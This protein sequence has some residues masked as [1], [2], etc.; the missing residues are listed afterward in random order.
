MEISFQIDSPEDNKGKCI[1]FWKFKRK[2]ELETIKSLTSKS[3]LLFDDFYEQSAIVDED[4]GKK[5]LYVGHDLI[6]KL[7][8]SDACRNFEDLFKHE[9]YLKWKGIITTKYPELSALFFVAEKKA[10][11]NQKLFQIENVLNKQKYGARFYNI[12]HNKEYIRSLK[13]RATELH[14][15]LDSKERGHEIVVG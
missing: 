13:Q 9:K 12:H 14:K 10:I 3:G 8:D 4:F 15:Q 1:C 11:I 7:P 5:P 2:Y 6:I